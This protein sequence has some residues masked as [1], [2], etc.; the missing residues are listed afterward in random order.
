MAKHGK[1]LDAKGYIGSNQKSADYPRS[2]DLSTS[3]HLTGAVHSWIFSRFTLKSL[4][5]SC[6]S[7]FTPCL[8]TEAVYL[9]VTLL[10]VFAKLLARSCESVFTL[11][12]PILP[13]PEKAFLGQ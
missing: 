7:V 1:I 3:C 4:N 12:H 2:F 8:L 13:P 10:Q 5:E 9:V 6:E 11:S